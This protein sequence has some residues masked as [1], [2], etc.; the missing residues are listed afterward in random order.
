M[1]QNLLAIGRL[2]AAECHGGESSDNKLDGPLGA[3]CQS[4]GDGNEE[5]TI[6]LI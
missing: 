5:L 2:T 6:D 3:T 4:S 1:S